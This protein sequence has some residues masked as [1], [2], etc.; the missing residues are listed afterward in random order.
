MYP[1]RNGTVTQT[2]Y[3]NPSA[4]VYIVSASTGNVEGLVKLKGEKQKY[5]AV[6]DDQHYGFGLLRVHNATHANWTFYESATLQV[7]DS[8]EIVK[9]RATSE[10]VVSGRL[11]ELWHALV[12]R[13]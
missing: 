3:N 10:R 13:D 5:T 7:L 2:D 12:G 8:V 4:P 9:E 11:S 1:L 6:L